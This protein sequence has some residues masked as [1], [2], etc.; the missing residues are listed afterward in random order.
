MNTASR[1]VNI[2]IFFL[3]SIHYLSI[4]GIYPVDHSQD[5]CEATIV[6]AYF[7]MTSKHSHDEYLSWMRNML[8]LRDCVV[9]FTESD[10]VDTIRSIRPVFYP[11]RIIVT[12]IAQVSI[13]LY[14]KL[15]V[16][17]CNFRPKPT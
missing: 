17:C 3:S 14:A 4:S 8:T 10:L 2:L 15:F 11:T 9:V 12:N 16:I 5:S 7:R 13:I 1:E 6:T